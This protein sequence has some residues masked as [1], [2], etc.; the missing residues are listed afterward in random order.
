M[1]E[2][3]AAAYF[4]YK[5][6]F[7]YMAASGTTRQVRLPQIHYAWLRDRLP[8]IERLV[9][10]IDKRPATSIVRKSEV[11]LRSKGMS[12]AQTSRLLRERHHLLEPAA[13]GPVQVEG[14]A[15]WPSRVVVHAKERHS[16]LEEHAQ[17]AAFLQTLATQCLDLT[18]VVA[19]SVGGEVQGFCELAKGLRTLPVF[20]RISARSSAKPAALLP[21]T[22]Q[23]TDRRYGRM[24]D[25]QAEYV[26][27]ISDSLNYTK[28]IRANVREVWDVYQT[29][30]AHVVGNA[31]GL[32]YFSEDKDLR[33]RSPQGWS[34]T[35]KDW[36]LYFD[37]KPPKGVLGSWRDATSRPADERPDIVL[38]NSHTSQV[39]LLDAKFK[40]DSAASHATQADLFEMQAYLNSYGATAGG[41]LF[42]GPSIA[43]NVIA[44]GGNALLELP[45]RANHFQAPGGAE[46]VHQH[47]RE[48]LSLFST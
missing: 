39:L 2:A 44:A 3:C 12:V 15:Y 18:T 33:K 36:Q 46:A 47:V 28:S 21:T 10:S 45:I 20:R 38:V 35:S 7:T 42:P 24:R 4:G 40:L 13:N 23:R 17:I 19:P 34:L 41:I 9:R 11:S 48:A 16:L 29:F 25:L 8:E 22:I 43:A 30:V 32:Q 5:R 31:L 1:A 14:A 6:Q 27:D 26:S 37:T